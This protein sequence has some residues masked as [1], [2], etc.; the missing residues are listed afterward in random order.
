LLY[1]RRTTQWQGDFEFKDKKNGLSCKLAFSKGKSLFNK[2]ALPIDCFE[3]TVTRHGVEVCK[4]QGS[5]LEFI[6]FNDRL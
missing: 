5:W 4:V 2:Q 6:R 3:G 1:G